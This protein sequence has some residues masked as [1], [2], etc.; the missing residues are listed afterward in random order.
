MDLEEKNILI[1]VIGSMLP[2]GIKCV[3]CDEYSHNDSNFATSIISVDRSGVDT[4][5]DHRKFGEFD[6]YLRPMDDIR[7]DEVKDLFNVMFPAFEMIGYDLEPDRIRYRAVE[8]DTRRF[9]HI[10]VPFGKVMSLEQF[11]WLNAHHFDY[12]GLIG[13][14]LA[15]PMR[16]EMYDVKYASSIKTDGELRE[17]KNEYWRK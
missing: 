1:S 17:L 12:R 16:K 5:N 6:I 14:F 11:D 9:S 10:V 7:D 15:R 13:T 3:E 2:Y 8:K 4:V